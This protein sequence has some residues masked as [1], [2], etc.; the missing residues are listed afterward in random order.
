VKRLQIRADEALIRRDR[1][2]PA[3]STKNKS[4]KVNLAAICFR[5]GTS[6]EADGGLLNHCA[7]NGCGYACAAGD[8]LAQFGD[9]LFMDLADAGFTNAHLLA[10]SF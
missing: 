4:H 8:Q 5:E 7:R 9:R 6:F 3:A 2:V 1:T 10:N